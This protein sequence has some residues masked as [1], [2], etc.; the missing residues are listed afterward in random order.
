MAVHLEGNKLFALFTVEVSSKEVYL[1]VGGK[2]GV[3]HR[4]VESTPTHIKMGS[5]PVPLAV[6]VV[7]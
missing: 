1:M 6:F 7:R 4:A 2:P 5:L 3:N